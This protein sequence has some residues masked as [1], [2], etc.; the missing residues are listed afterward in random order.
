MS[1]RLV[2]HC[3]H[4][5]GHWTG[6]LSLSLS[7]LPPKYSFLARSINFY[8]YVHDEAYNNGENACTR[9]SRTRSFTHSSTS[10]MKSTS[11]FPFS[12]H[13]LNFCN[14][15][16]NF[17][18]VSLGFLYQ[19]KSLL[20]HCAK[21]FKGWVEVEGKKLKLA[22]LDISEKVARLVTSF[23]FALLPF[24][25]HWLVA[26]SDYIVCRRFFTCSQCTEAKLLLFSTQHFLTLHPSPSLN[27]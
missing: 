22:Q 1:A 15:L 12:S 7:P 10:P 24:N 2:C 13:S 25:H 21:R 3:A 4:Y 19:N 17:S 6:S 27:S 8:V 20:D 16:W 11:P 26:H 23:I 18:F 5:I 14:L 9:F